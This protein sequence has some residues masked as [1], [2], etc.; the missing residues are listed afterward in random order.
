VAVLPTAMPDV[1]DIIRIL[2]GGSAKRHSWTVRAHG[3]IL[4][5]T[6]ARRTPRRRARRANDAR[7]SGLSRTRACL[8]SQVTSMRLSFL[9]SALRLKR[10]QPEKEER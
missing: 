2:R 5:D 4:T 3:P 7:W 8:D 10:D 1:S 6:R 9:S